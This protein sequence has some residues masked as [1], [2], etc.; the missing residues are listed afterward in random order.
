[1]NNA[2]L[3]DIIKH[4]SAYQGVI[5]PDTPINFYSL[6]KKVFEKASDG[7]KGNK[8]TEIYKMID[9]SKTD[10][11]TFFNSDD[12]D[13]SEDIYGMLSN[14]SG[15]RRLDL[16]FIGYIYTN[17]VRTDDETGSKLCVTEIP[18]PV[19]F[20]LQFSVDAETGAYQGI[21]VFL[22]TES[23]AISNTVKIGGDLIFKAYGHTDF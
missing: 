16:I 13:I 1:M 19:S 9:F 21:E 18:I 12:P 8:R 14:V 17:R 2:Y 11:D 3:R 22:E 6:C 20:T 7:N 4:D 15:L 5:T 23:G 10:F